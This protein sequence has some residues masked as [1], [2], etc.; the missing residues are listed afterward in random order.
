MISKGVVIGAGIMGVGIAQVLAMAQVRVRLYDTSAAQRAA[1][2]ERIAANLNL[3]VAHDLLTAEGAEQ[4]LTRVTVEELLP[5]A[6]DGAEIVVEAIPERLDWKLD[7]YEQ[8]EALVPAATI[9]AS[10][11]STF[12]IEAL[13]QRL[14]HP[15]RFIITHFFNPAELVPLVEV[16]TRENTA[17][18]VVAT[19]LD[20]LQQAGKKPVRLQKDIPG[21]V[22]NRLQ[23]ALLREALV[24]I[25]EGVVSP[26]DLDTVV[27]SGIGFRWAFL[28]PLEIAD[29]GGL[30]TWKYVTEN[31]FPLLDRTA[32]PPPALTDR[33]ERGELGIKSGQG[34]YHYGPD[35]LRDRLTTRDA[36]FIGLLRAKRG[37]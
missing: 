15:R 25:Q 10:N 18:S 20:L 19:T 30:D 14:A 32:A 28:G 23:A 7:L 9:I 27:S 29:F 11:T 22:A 34:F 6:I 24:L 37:T 1:A 8:I 35:E 13:T 2:E 21:F 31:L 26:E 3:L 4:I 17:E 12:P 36:N 16:I 5:A 33:V